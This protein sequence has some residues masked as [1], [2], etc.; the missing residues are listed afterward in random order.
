MKTQSTDSGVL[1]VTTLETDFSPYVY[2]R[3]FVESAVTL[4]TSAAPPHQIED[5][6]GVF[7][8]N[9]PNFQIHLRERH[10]AHKLRSPARKTPANTGKTPAS[11][12]GEMLEMNARPEVKQILIAKRMKRWHSIARYPLFDPKCKPARARR[13]AMRLMKKYPMIAE[14]L[15]IDVVSLYQ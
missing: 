4:S 15:K 11:Q 1:A 10:F 5:S 2:K 9:F 3:N 12:F 7:A 6:S 8:V 13:N 14:A